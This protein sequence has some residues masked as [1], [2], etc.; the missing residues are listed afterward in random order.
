MRI[1][2]HQHCNMLVL[3][4]QDTAHENEPKGYKPASAILEL[5]W[6][7]GRNGI[8]IKLLQIIKKDALTGSKHFAYL[9]Y[10]SLLALGLMKPVWNCNWNMRIDV[11]LPW[12]FPPRVDLPWYTVIVT[13]P[14]RVRFTGKVTFPSL[15]VNSLKQEEQCLKIKLLFSLGKNRVFS[16][17]K[18][19]FPF[20]NE[21]KLWCNL[22]QNSN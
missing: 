14:C 3:N 2:N 11:I 21:Q 7:H 15:R 18:P 16:V 8:L 6:M 4:H 20:I 22:S 9:E 10:L 5:G 13:S 1:A 17:T 19:N 12:T